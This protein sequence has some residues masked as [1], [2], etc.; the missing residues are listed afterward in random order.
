MLPNK[1]TERLVGFA[2]CSNANSVSKQ[3]PKAQTSHIK[4]CLSSMPPWPWYS[5]PLCSAP[6][7]SPC[8]GILSLFSFPLCT[9]FLH[10]FSFSRV[11]LCPPLSTHLHPPL[12]P[13]LLFP[14]SFPHSEALLP[15]FTLAQLPTLTHQCHQGPKGL[16]IKK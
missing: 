16:K 14:S 7:L 12:G 3:S 10:C 5:L 4:T 2:F 9:S 6:F 8:P 15:V 13:L 1:C 11:I